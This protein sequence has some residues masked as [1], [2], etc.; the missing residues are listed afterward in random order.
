MTNH[1]PGTSPH[2]HSSFFHRHSDG[3]K[4][5]FIGDVHGYAKELE[6]LLKKLGYQYKHQTWSHHEYKAVFV[7]DFINR[8]PE[9]RKVIEIIKSMV[10]NGYGFA[11]LGNHEINAICYFTRRKD[12][13]PIRLPGPANKKLLDKVK[14][15]YNGD[16]ELFTQHIKWLRRQPLF[17]DFGTVRTAHAY[18]SDANIELLKGAIPQP[19]LKKKFLLEMMKGGTAVSKAFMQTIKGIE[20]SFPPNI[21]VKD[22]LKVRRFWYRVKWWESPYNKTFEQLSFETKFNL[23]NILVPNHLVYP[24]DVYE[25]HQPPMFFGHYCIGPTNQIPSSNICCIDACVANGGKLA[26]YRWQGETKLNSHHIIFAD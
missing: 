22:N 26:A 25:K 9:S 11:I 24:F 4:Y 5:D 20:Y 18:W 14:R 8:G 2:A 16:D 3:Q 12:G 19:K 1:S 21:V 17:I 6:T 23:P 15:E 10:D 13:R 7:G